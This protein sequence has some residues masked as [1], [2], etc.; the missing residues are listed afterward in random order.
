MIRIQNFGPG[1]HVGQFTTP[2]TGLKL[3]AFLKAAR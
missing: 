1:Q 2:R 3:L